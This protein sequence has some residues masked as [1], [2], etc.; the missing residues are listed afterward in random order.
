MLD[1]IK[2]LFNSG[3]ITVP[4]FKI[5]TIASSFGSNLVK[6]GKILF[7]L[8]GESLCFLSGCRMC[9]AIEGETRGRKTF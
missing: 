7:A 2:N 9:Y 6:L 5:Q 4:I 3:Y 8:I 1:Y